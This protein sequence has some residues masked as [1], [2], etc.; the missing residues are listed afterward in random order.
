M[1][2]DYYKSMERTRQDAMIELERA[3]KLYYQIM[4]SPE[5]LT[6]N[7]QL[8]I[9]SLG[10]STI[11]AVL[12]LPPKVTQKMTREACRLAR[13]I[14]GNKC[15]RHLREEEGKFAWLSWNREIKDNHGKY[16]IGVFVENANPGK[17]KLV[18]KKKTVVYFE[19][20]CKVD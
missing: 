8:S 11:R 4:S 2:K 13:K 16:D 15:E 5:A 12:Y 10:A 1:I 9:D 6:I 14:T 17:C 20:D 19:T 3:E 7:A 18:K